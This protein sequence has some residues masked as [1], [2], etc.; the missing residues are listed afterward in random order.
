MKRKG[1]RLEKRVWP[2]NLIPWSPPPLPTPPPRPSSALLVG[3]PTLLVARLLSLLP[4]ALSSRSTG[5]LDFMVSG[6]LGA[7]AG[8]EQCW[9][10]ARGFLE[11]AWRRQ[12]LPLGGG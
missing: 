2:G 3:T 12:P 9:G 7:A 4:R 6:C 10:Q 1:R 11:A 5:P 8:P